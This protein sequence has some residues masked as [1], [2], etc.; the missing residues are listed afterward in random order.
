MAPWLKKIQIDGTT[1]GVEGGVCAIGQHT[2]QKL[3]QL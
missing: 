1:R 2:V 3:L